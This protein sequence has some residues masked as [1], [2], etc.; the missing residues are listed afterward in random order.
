[1]NLSMHKF[2]V[3]EVKAELSPLDGGAADLKEETKKWILNKGKPKE[4]QFETGQTN[5]P[6][7]KTRGHV[8]HGLVDTVYLAY[9]KHRP[10]ELSV[11]DFWVLIAHGVGKHMAQHA[12]KYRGQFVNHAEQN[13]LD[14]NVQTIG[15]Q[16]YDGSS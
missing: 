15:I 9:C 4:H 7:V 1:M 16:P 8:K 11:D 10:L 5:Y 6:L 2:S 13:T 12:E 3:N 14:L